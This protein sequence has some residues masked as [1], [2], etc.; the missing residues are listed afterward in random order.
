MP[1]MMAIYL[2][3]EKELFV[4][5]AFLFLLCTLAEIKEMV[6]SD[7]SY[8]I[9]PWRSATQGSKIHLNTSA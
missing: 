4:H 1:G 7:T 8:I 2:F 3:P 6:C 5:L 9:D